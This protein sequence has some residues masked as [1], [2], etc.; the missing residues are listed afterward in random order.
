MLV[1]VSILSAKNFEA[2][3]GGDD[4]SDNLTTLINSLVG[5]F[6]IMVFWQ[7]EAKENLE[8]KKQLEEKEDNLKEI[9]NLF[10]SG[11]LFYDQRKGLIYK[12][13]QFQEICKTLSLH[14]EESK[15]MKKN[16][17][18]IVLKKRSSLLKN[19]L[20]LKDDSGDK[21]SSEV[22]GYFKDK[23]QEGTT[24]ADSLKELSLSV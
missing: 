23:D 4:F 22:L 18:G 11:I 7:A 24:L 12:N 10:P 9:L 5:S 21:S 13:K 3:T 6:F 16:S 8:G 17:S 1:S 15:I 2:F 14:N 20:D 19:N